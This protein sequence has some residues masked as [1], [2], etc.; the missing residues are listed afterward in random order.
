MRAIGITL[1]FATTIS[2]TTF[3]SAESARSGASYDRGNRLLALGQL[4]GALAA[5]AEAAQ[6]DRTNATY[7]QQF[8]LV[9]RALV[10]KQSLRQEQNLQRWGVPR[11]ATLR[12]GRHSAGVS[13]MPYLDRRASTPV[14][15]SPKMHVG[16][17]HHS[18]AIL[19]LWY[20]TSASS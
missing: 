20:G 18:A 7:M 9:R 8:T 4:Q 5:Y 17:L 16:A 13:S 14:G 2:L 6:G 12:A 11:R 19:L 15:D 1:L 10:L 3:V